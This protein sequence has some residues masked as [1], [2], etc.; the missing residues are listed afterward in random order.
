LRLLVRT[1]RAIAGLRRAHP[2]WGPRRLVFELAKR[3]RQLGLR[4]VPGESAVY[5]VLVRLNLI[6]P[7]GRRPRDRRWR[8]WERGAPME[9]WQMDV[10]G[11]FVL[12]DGRRAKALTAV[13]D[14]SRFCVSAFLMLRESSQRVC[15]VLASPACRKACGVDRE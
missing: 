7:S 1:P 2:S 13:D 15:D 9:L 3:R 6:E 5:R 11:G 10:V 8:R 12:V 4:Q 14:H